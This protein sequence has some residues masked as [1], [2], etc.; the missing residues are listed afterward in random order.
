MNTA[1]VGFERGGVAAWLA[2]A[3][4]VFAGQPDVLRALSPQVA[5]EVH[6][7]PARYEAALRA[8]SRRDDAALAI[9]L[10]MPFCASH[11]LCCERSIRAAQPAAVIDAYVD[12]LCAELQ[13]LAAATGPRDV[14]Q[15]TVGNGCANELDDSQL[16]RLVTT[17]QRHWRLTAD[18]DMAAE[19]DPRR[20]SDSQLALLR[21]FGFRRLTFGVLD[22]DTQVQSAIGRCQ[23]G[24]LVD[25]VC[26]R[27]RAAGIRS[28]N[29]DLMAGLPRQTE[30][31]WQR[32]LRRVVAMAP[33]RV[34]IARYRHR[35]WMAPVQ[36]LIDPEEV[37]DE[38]RTQALVVHAG[39]A[40]RAAGYRWIGADHFVLDGDE[41]ALA[42]D[43]GRLRRNLAGYSGR[44]VGPV[45]GVGIGA[46]SDV[47]GHLYWNEPLPETWAARLREGLLP[48][49]C[50]RPSTPAERRRRR[51]VEH[52]LCSLELRAEHARG[53]L[54]AA[55][56]QLADREREGW[57]RALDDRIVVTD[58][59]RGC[60]HDLC[61]AFGAVA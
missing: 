19:C 54:E 1:G 61:A 53:G 30:A 56:A 10:R 20:V 15:L 22:L 9:A 35:P 8:L 51:A 41:L 52:L 40:L 57:V 5:A 27:A 34:T 26:E 23:T 17:L 49:A 4:P 38:A 55:Y 39:Q 13:R 60:L 44:D 36:S 25:D 48:V 31:G 42:F 45:I 16:A 58:Q 21:G 59:G 7:V 37:P 2:R 29:L 47:D 32:T 33:D 3:D 11:C 18:A 50:T 46:V 12:D 43:E 24:A 28:V 14:L 6:D